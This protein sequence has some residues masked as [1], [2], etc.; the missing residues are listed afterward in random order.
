MA[1][2]A[3]YVKKSKLLKN[4]KTKPKCPVGSKGFDE[5]LK[6]HKTVEHVP[7]SIRKKNEK[8]IIFIV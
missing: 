3:K 1:E 8:C 6:W 7:R 5:M 4:Q 2:K